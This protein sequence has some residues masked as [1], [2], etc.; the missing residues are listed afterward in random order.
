MTDGLRVLGYG[1]TDMPEDCRSTTVAS[2]T[3]KMTAVERL[4]LLPLLCAAFLLE[5]SIKDWLM[6]TDAGD[7]ST[8]DLVKEIFK[9][10]S[11][12]SVEEDS[13]VFVQSYTN[14]LNSIAKANVIPAK[15]EAALARIPRAQD[16]V[17]APEIRKLL[18]R[19]AKY[20]L[21]RTPKRE[22]Q[23][24]Q[25]VQQ[26]KTLEEMDAYEVLERMFKGNGG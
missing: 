24:Q 22:T 15:T 20:D 26:T 17:R 9:Y 7:R 16:I 8:V 11:P 4:L 14:V 3:S 13:K 18:A 2:V 19:R 5:A 12:S 10:N 21:R 25:E 6:I 1:P 23:P